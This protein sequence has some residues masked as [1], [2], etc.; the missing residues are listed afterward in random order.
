MHKQRGDRG[1]SKT[2]SA[3]GRGRI[4]GQIIYWMNWS[5]LFF[6]QVMNPEFVA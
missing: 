2:Y 3:R 6:F 5:H 1:R 4:L